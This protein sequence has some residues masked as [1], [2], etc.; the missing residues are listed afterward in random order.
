M[1]SEIFIDCFFNDFIDNDKNYY[2]KRKMGKVLVIVINASNWNYIQN[3]LR[4][5][6]SCTQCHGTSSS[7]NTDQRVTDKFERIYE[8]KCSLWLFIV[9]DDTESVFKEVHFSYRC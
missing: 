5:D 1:S 3:T 9:V 7:N 6:V 4:V 2:K 8:N